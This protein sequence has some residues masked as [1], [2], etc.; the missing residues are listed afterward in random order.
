[1][2]IL[3]IADNHDSGA[4]IVIDG[5]I[6][7]AVNQERVDRVK[8]SGAFPWGAIDQLCVDH[9]IAYK[10]IDRIAIGSSFTP[11]AILR[12]N[13]SSHQHAK[14]EGQF[15]ILLHGY[16]LYQSSLRKTGLYTLEIDACRQ[17]IKH[18]LKER[19]FASPEIHMLDHHYCHAESA[20]RTQSKAK[21]LVF[22]VDAMGD[23]LSATVSIGENADLRTIHTQSGLST[24][25]LFYSRI[26]ELLGF[27]PLR[28]EGKVT[29]LAAMAEAP[30]ALVTH[31]SKEISSAKGKFPR[32]SLAN[33][34]HP[35]DH[36][37]KVT[38]EYSK[39][40]IAAAAQ[41]V[42]ETAVSAHIRYWIQQT[43]IRDICLAGG[44]FANVK[45]NQRIADIAE[46]QSLWVVPHMGD[47]GLAMGAALACADSPPQALSHAYLGFSPS[48]QDI[49]KAIKRN[50]LPHTQAKTSAIADILCTGGVVARC[51]GAM[52]WGPRA[53][54]NRSLLAL[55]Q[56]ASINDRLNAKLQRSEF[57]PFAPIVRDIDTQKYFTH[58]E[59]IAEA[60][61]FMTVCTPTTALFRE[62]CPAAVHVDGTA[63]PQILRRETNPELYEL[64]GEIAKR[65]GHGVLINTSFNM[66]EE[67][68]VCTA[69]DALRGFLSAQIEALWIGEYLVQSI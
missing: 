68:I 26:T 65:T 1:M 59:K 27:T 32:I 6:I 31:F 10:D 48:R 3:G 35:N 13:P 51:S 42:L 5:K 23:G 41:K 58:T 43:N 25:S 38:K 57:M 63:R 24:V 54:G 36:F 9:N 47:G 16:L 45:L 40:E 15:S 14:L 20:Y 53:L 61:E 46:V 50:N 44:I 18:K 37:W 69:D 2:I 56:D 30:P 55:A 4:A 21:V 29:G 66:H 49:I 60:L 7:G 34:A 8:N 28:H 67:P 52:E 19:P 62:H 33:P 12:S 64:L 17:I 39:A 22:T 11:S